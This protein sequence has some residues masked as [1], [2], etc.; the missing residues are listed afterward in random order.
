MHWTYIHAY[1]C[2]YIHTNIHVLGGTKTTNNNK[3]TIVSFVPTETNGIIQHMPPGNY[4]STQHTKKMIIT[5]AQRRLRKISTRSS[6]SGAH[7]ASS[8]SSHQTLEKRA[9]STVHV[10]SP[11]PTNL[12]T[13][14]GQIDSQGEPRERT[15]ATP[16]HDIARARFFL[17]RICR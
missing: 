13:T 8:L 14:Y 5:T 12:S 1:V 6:I 9:V 17:Q 4:I 2:A 16:I 7:T 11:V 3:P 15:N 10:A